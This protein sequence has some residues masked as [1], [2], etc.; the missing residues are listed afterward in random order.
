MI[1]NISELRVLFMGTPDFAVASL[2]ALMKNGCN[3][4]GV[5][6]VPDKPAGRGLKMQMSDVKIIA[7]QYNLPVIQPEN[8]NDELFQQLL[9]SLNIDLTV[10]VAFK[11]LPK[12]I[13]S[14]PKL[15]T[16]NLHAS[17][18][19]DF[20]GAAPINWA[21][22]KGITTT[23]VTTFFINDKI[24]EGNILLQ[25]PVEI[26]AHENFGDLYNKLKEV[27]A[28]LLIETLK[29]LISGNYSPQNQ[30]DLI[31]N[32]QILHKAPKI[33][34][35]MCRINWGTS[36]KEVNNFVRGLNPFPGAYTEIVSPDGVLHYLKVFGVRA[37]CQ[38][39]EYEAGKILS[40]GK[41]FLHIVSKDGLVAL[42]EIQLAG[43]KKMAI[44]EFLKGFAVNINWMVKPS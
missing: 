10:V 33:T 23:G 25:Q 29:I 27:G 37:I 38:Q 34:K 31:K 41:T 2:H 30:L 28:H 42:E 24:D 9:F 6:T 18:L 36:A 39:T 21:I 11:K 1:M 44:S 14:I 32:R 40:D 3:I 13:W 15:G 4:V 26:T 43:K 7:N 17:L 20:R 35:E 16:I 8:F 19:P 5:V 22:I 12:S